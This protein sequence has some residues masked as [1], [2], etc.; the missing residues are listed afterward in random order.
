VAAAV[1]GARRGGV[2]PVGSRAQVGERARG[3]RV[4]SPGQNGGGA[5]VR[6]EGE[7]ETRGWGGPHR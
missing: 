4:R 2:D 3:Q 1:L 6:C 5:S 7:E